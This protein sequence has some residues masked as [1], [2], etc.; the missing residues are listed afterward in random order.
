MN[1][2]SKDSA[3]LPVRVPSCELGQ[4]PSPEEPVALA[5]P[6]RPAPGFL[7]SLGWLFVLFLVS[8]V[9]PL[10]VLMLAGG[11]DLDFIQ[12][13]FPAVF[14]G[15]VLG[16]GLAILLLRQRLSR[17]WLA[18]LGLSRLPLLQTFLAVLCIPGLQVITNGIVHLCRI[19]VGSQDE[20]G[21]M[22]QQTA[23]GQPWWLVL[24]AIAVGPALNE[25]LWFRGFLGR[26][27]VGRYGA[28]VGIV[29]A[30]VLFGIFHMP[31]MV[32]ALY[33]IILGLALHLMYRATRSLW[34]PIVFHFLF[35]SVAVGAS[36]LLAGS[37]PTELDSTA[38]AIVALVCGVALTVLAV[39]GWGL[40]RLR[41]RG[42]ETTN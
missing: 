39:A 22:I 10:F 38:W 32:Q 30:S 7:G 34:V 8:Q 37:Q 20:V 31:N 15:Q 3:V 29:L 23:P 33:A 25:E 2:S 12:V 27:L 40:Y 24:L 42:V 9:I 17:H 4:A 19:L 36:Y 21:N 16:V 11:L 1:A 5:Q 41:A 28:V 18:E 13:F 6:T 14:G 35:N 26:G